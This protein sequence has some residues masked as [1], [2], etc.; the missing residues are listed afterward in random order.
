M[1]ISVSRLNQRI[2]LQ[3]PAELPLG[4]VFVVGQIEMGAPR[5][6]SKGSHPGEFHLV[7]EGFRLPCRLSARAAAEF[8]L[9]DGDLV[10][11]GGHLVFEPALASYYLLARDIERLDGFRPASRPLAAIIA[12]SNR[13]QRTPSLAAADLPAWVQRMAPPETRPRKVDTLTSAMTTSGPLSGG[14]WEL[15]VDAE[16]AVAYPAAEPAL[17]GLSDELIAFLSQAMDSEVEVEITSEIMSDLN[18][19]GT[20]ERLSPEVLDALD[21]FEANMSRE[22]QSLKSGR[23]APAAAGGQG[24]SQR[25]STGRSEQGWIGGNGNSQGAAAE[26]LAPADIVEA[27]ESVAVGKSPRKRKQA[28]ARK[29]KAARR[30]KSGVPWYVVLVTVL[31][32]VII[33]AAI[34][35]ILQYSGMISVDLP[36]DLPQGLSLFN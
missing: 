3:L 10:R 21:L 28:A 31:M 34:F 8:R 18:A 9:Q 25:Q 32:V 13:R 22:K 1:D 15:L 6:S 35:F 20:T 12:D 7:D 14:D 26:R 2:A 33:L 16:A 5:G 4:L 23:T 24:P 27:L 36:F 11:A 19:T 29:R 30:A 17:A